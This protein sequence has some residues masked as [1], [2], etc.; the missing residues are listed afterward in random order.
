LLPRR[1]FIATIATGVVALGVGGGSTVAVAAP[2][3][4][5]ASCTAHFVHGPMG[6]PG[7]FRSQFRN[8]YNEPFGRSVS[9]YSSEHE[10]GSFEECRTE[11]P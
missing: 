2:P 7:Q 1:R 8:E 4:E 11:Q 9:H 6:P 5:H 10:G 3:D